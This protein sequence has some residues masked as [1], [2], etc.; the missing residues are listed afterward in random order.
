[1]GGTTL[2]GATPDSSGSQ[3]AWNGTGSGCSSL[4]PKPAW[5]QGA[6]PSACQNR[7]ETDVAAD[8]D[9]HTPVAI[10]DSAGSTV[11][12]IATGWNAAGGTSVATPIIAAS[13]ALAGRPAP[14]TYPASYPYQHPRRLHR[15][16]VGLERPVRGDRR[17]LCT[18]RAGYDGPTGLGTPCGPGGL[19]GTPGRR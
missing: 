16:D 17:Y 10:Y 12:G 13:Y 7:T 19:A 1:M 2:I 5:Q 3:T 18:A 11:P 6:T 9:P 14:G 8:A 4:E 15:R